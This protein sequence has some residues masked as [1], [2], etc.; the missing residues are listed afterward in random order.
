MLRDADD[1]KGA[2][3]VADRGR[4]LAP[5]SPG[6][7][8]CE[9]LVRAIEAPELAPKCE[10]VWNAP[11]PR[12][13]IAYKN[14]SKVYFRA[15]RWD[16]K[17]FLG[18]E[19]GRPESLNDAE[20]AALLATEPAKAWSA[21][22]PA[23]PDFRSRSERLLAPQDLAPG[24]YFLLASDDENFTEKPTPSFSPTSG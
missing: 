19:H 10:R 24:F 16:W 1:A 20:R 21:D 9:N 7:A 14:V 4:K 11:W 8:R 3:A 23:T 2:R 5:G 6:A 22:L 15:V 17:Q 13:A 12:I 18:R